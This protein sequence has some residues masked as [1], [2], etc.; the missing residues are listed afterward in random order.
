M[1]IWEGLFEAF[2]QIMLQLV[3]ISVESS[4]CKNVA[5]TLGLRNK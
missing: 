1:G 3:S 5:L 2:Q 4:P